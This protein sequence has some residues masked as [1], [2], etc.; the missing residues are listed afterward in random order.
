MDRIS[1]RLMRCI[2]TGVLFPFYYV[3]LSVVGVF[4]AD[5]SLTASL[6]RI[7]SL[8]E[9]PGPKRVCMPRFDWP[10][11]FFW[12]SGQSK[13]FLGF[14]RV[15][16]LMEQWNSHVQLKAQIN[17]GSILLVLVALKLIIYSRKNRHF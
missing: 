16:K 9:P 7:F 1:I 17:V 2:F 13:T 5:L 10:E 12:T 8:L 3:K 15:V 14:P 4:S 11:G 6:F